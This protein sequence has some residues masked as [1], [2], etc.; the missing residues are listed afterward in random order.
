MSLYEKIKNRDTELQ[1]AYDLYI[2]DLNKCKLQISELKNQ[3]IKE[4]KRLK[5][6]DLQIKNCK[7]RA[8]EQGFSNLL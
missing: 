7:E 3:L 4:K 1:R 5:L 6:I 2:E 8:I